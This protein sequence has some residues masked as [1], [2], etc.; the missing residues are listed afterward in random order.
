[1]AQ[2]ELSGFA[3]RQV[4]ALLVWRRRE[5]LPAVAQA[6][7]PEQPVSLQREER[8]KRAQPAPQL[9]APEDVQRELAVRQQERAPEASSERDFA[10]VVA[11]AEPQEQVVSLQPA[12]AQEQPASGEPPSAQLLS[13]PFRLPP[14][15]R[16]RH[17]ARLGPESCGEPSPRHRQ[18][19]SLSASFFPRHRS[20]AK[21]Q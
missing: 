11:L 7:L 5:E 9:Q 4:G 1:L 6:E 13:R 16:R 21:G 15:L 14:Q 19:S 12:E 8:W 17:P 10:A 20:Q 3:A 2:A 18:G